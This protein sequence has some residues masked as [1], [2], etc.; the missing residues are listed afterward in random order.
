MIFQ[1]CGKCSRFSFF[2]RAYC[3]I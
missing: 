2:H 3:E 1:Y